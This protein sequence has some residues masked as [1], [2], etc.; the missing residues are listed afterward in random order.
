MET[1]SIITA[2]AIGYFLGAIPFGY[3]YSRIFLGIDIR[4]VGSGKTSTTNTLRAGG[5]KIALLTIFSDAA[6]GSLAVILT[7][8]LL[9]N[10][11]GIAAAAGTMAVLGHNWSVF[12]GFKGGAGATT[13]GAV[14]IT[15][16]PWIICIIPILIPLYLITRYASVTSA[17]S[18]IFIFTIFLIRN[19]IGLDHSWWYVIY[20]SLST[21]MIAIA[22]LPNFKRLAKGA[23]LTFDDL[24]PPH[25]K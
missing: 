17:T 23:E 24:N 11:P 12:I 10:S 13:N 18:A 15:I 6:K 2:A 19:I 22:L 20:S 7:R 9:G 16:F 3:I 21:C 14:A 25:Q 4:T 8:A 5:T 1:I